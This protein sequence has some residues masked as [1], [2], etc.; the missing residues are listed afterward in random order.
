MALGRKPIEIV[1]EG[2]HQLLVKAPH[3]GR[4]NLGEIAQVQNGFAFSSKQF[5]KD[6]GI[7][8][9][10]IRDID[11]E[12]TVDRYVG[13]YS[14]EYLVSKGDVLIGMDGDFKAAKWNGNRALLNQ[15]VCRIILK[16]LDFHKEFLFICLQPYLNAINA[17]TS[18]VTVKHLS[19]RTLEEIPL[20]CPPFKEQERIVAKI[21]EL[22]S[23]LDDG[24]G[25]LK[26]AQAQLKTYRQA[27]LKSAFEG[28]LTND[29]LSDGELPDRW[30]LVKLA[31]IATSRLGKMLDRTKNVG[32]LQPYLRNINVRWGSFDLSNLLEMRFEK[33]EADKFGLKKGD[34]VICEGGEPGRAA[35]WKE[36]DAQMKIQKALHRVRFSNT[37]SPIFFLYFLAYSARSKVLDKYFTGTTI[38]HLT[39]ESLRQIEFPFPPIEEQQRI[40]EEIER[41]LSVCEKLEETINAGLKQSEALRQSILKQAFDGKLVAQ[42]SAAVYQP[43]NINFYRIQVLA[44]MLIYFRRR[45]FHLAEM[46]SAKNAYLLDK[47]FE[48]PIYGNYKRW[49]L[50]PYSAEIKKTINNKKYFRIGGYKKID[51]L[52]EETLLKYSN[53]YRQKIEDAVSELAEIYQ[54]FDDPKTQAHKI[55]LLATVC[56][57]IEDIKTIEIKPVRQSMNEWIIDLPDKKFKNKAEKFDVTETEKCI[58]FIQKKGWDKKL[59]QTN[60]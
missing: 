17:E 34:L 15:R 19:S 14:D 51:V 57:V 44:L 9:I 29:N 37:T 40:V 11:K 30:K 48:I 4:V 36:S 59:V 35:I 42:E 18:S 58:A 45:G 60:G 52:N 31:D 23:E 13:N 20:P 33:E 8:L 32:D 55:E 6:K 38:K 7:P 12:T 54:S 5:T 26:K 41:R 25:S 10:R 49:H 2:K 46:T 43:K 53:P 16:S 39:G 1:N 28:E 22:F 27:V 3:W 47:I 21:E 50:G 24:V 56:K